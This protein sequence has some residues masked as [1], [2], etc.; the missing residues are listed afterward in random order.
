MTV[1][2]FPSPTS[3]LCSAREGN[4][5]VCPP[6]N[7]S[8]STWRK[9][10]CADCLELRLPWEIP[11]APVQESRVARVVRSATKLGASHLCASGRPRQKRGFVS[12]WTPTCLFAWNRGSKN[13]RRVHGTP[14]HM[15]CGTRCVLVCTAFSWVRPI[16]THPSV[17]D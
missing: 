4:K 17:R 11:H 2:C 16:S 1:T 7:W 8:C 3:G 9:A 14:V 15:G 12:H 5:F 13:Q 10:G 6:E